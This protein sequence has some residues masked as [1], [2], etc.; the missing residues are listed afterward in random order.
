MERLLNDSH[1]KSENDK[2]KSYVPSDETPAHDVNDAHK[3]V[4]IRPHRYI[5]LVDDYS[6][7][8]ETAAMLEE[9]GGPKSILK[10]TALFYQKAFADAVLSPF[11]RNK[12]DPHFSRLG[13]WIIEKMDPLQ[14][15]WTQERYIR[16]SNQCPVMLANGQRHV[17][18][19][20]TSAHVA[21][22]Y[23]PNR[24]PQDVGKHF[25]LHDCRAWMRLMFWS[26]RETGVFD[27]SPTFEDWYIRFIADFVSVY[28]SEAPQFAR[29][30]SR[31]S[32]N[33]DNLTKYLANKNDLG[34]LVMDTQI[35]PNVSVR[36]AR[37]ELPN[38]EYREHS[39][40]PYIRV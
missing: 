29:E 7:G 10:M 26:A 31:W 28:E 24:P 1:I 12:T 17:I 22:W 4:T 3:S 34:Y 19:D 23:S 38:M 8:T 37:R 16:N 40:W 32:K 6:R 35:S 20:R 5:R 18:H 25:K 11:I 27:L 13:N 2:L 9:I 30:S 36:E 15:L 21:A 33:P 39:N 14:D